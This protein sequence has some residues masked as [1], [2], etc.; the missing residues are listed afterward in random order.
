VQ[1]HV[2]LPKCKDILRDQLLSVKDI[3]VWPIVLVLKITVPSSNSSDKVFW[4]PITMFMCIFW[5]GLGSYVIV[6]LITIIG[7]YLLKNN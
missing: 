6:E 2:E 5:I 3:L 7:V 1:E 4:V